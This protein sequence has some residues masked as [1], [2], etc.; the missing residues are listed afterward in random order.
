MKS[1]LKALLLIGLALAL[2][3]CGSSKPACDAYSDNV[4]T[5]ENN[6]INHG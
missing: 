4:D 1:F 2:I 5:V 3:G 6:T